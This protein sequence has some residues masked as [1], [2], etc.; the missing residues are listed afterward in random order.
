MKN[1]IPVLLC[2]IFCFNIQA[3][4]TIYFH[5]QDKEIAK[6]QEINPTEVVYK[7]MSYLDGPVF[8]SLKTEIDSIRF[9]N[10]IKIVFVGSTD[11]TKDAN[12]STYVEPARD[13]KSERDSYAQGVADADQYY[14][15]YKGIGT[16]CFFSGLVGIYGFPVPLVGSLTRPNNMLRYVPDG[17][18]YNSDAPY[19][20]GYNSRAR[21]MKANKAWA[22]YGYGAA[23]TTGVFLI[24]L[25]AVLNGVN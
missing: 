23:T 1:T 4:D 21:T 12:G 15:G 22:N 7:K 6:I 9:S 24:V 14:R 3:Q 2:L 25:F 17:K 16:A 8:R 18:R 20:N 13:V 10:G 5:K 11:N 19:F